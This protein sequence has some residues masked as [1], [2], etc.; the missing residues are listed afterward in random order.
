M[1]I[2]III[3][4]YNEE[5]SIGALLDN[6]KSLKG[7]FEVIFSDGGS[8][9]N[10]INYINGNYNTVYS[11]KGRANQMNTGSEKSL[12]DILLFL[13]CDSILESDALLK[14]EEKINEGYSAGCLRIKF[15]SR[16][17]LMKCCG[18]LSNFRVKS[19]QIAFGDQGIFMKREV[20][21]EIGGIPNL[22]IMEDYQLSLNIN[23][24]YKICQANTV[25][26]T[27]SRRFESDG[28]IKTMWK[29]QKYQRMFRKGVN[30][31]IIHKM[32]RDVR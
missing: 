7:E 5:K 18:V 15:D 13:H 29:M 16:N 27:S 6:L 12:G 21:S 20:F 25:I 32:Y 3:P 14:I 11:E 22:P 26:L 10:T 31:D 28:I 19:R 8:S 30:P 2:S 9:D 4:I 24:K 1:K 17:L 23:K